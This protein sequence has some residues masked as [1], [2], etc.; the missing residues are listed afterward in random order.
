MRS[1]IS[2][3]GGQTIKGGKGKSDFV[4]LV[5]LS[6]DTGSVPPPW[7]SCESVS[8]KGKIESLTH[9]QVDAS[10][11]TALQ[12]KFQSLLTEMGTQLGGRY[13]VGAGKLQV[14][15]DVSND[16]LGSGCTGDVLLARS[17]SDSESLFAVKTYEFSKLA[18]E[19]DW[20]LLKIE[21]KLLLQSD[22]QNVLR[23]SDIYEEHNALHIVTPFMAGGDLR[24]A[25]LSELQIKM[26]AMQMLAG[27]QYLHGL[28]YIHRDIKPANFVFDSNDDVKIIDFGLCATWK[29]SG[30]RM[31]RQCG[32]HGF[33]SPEMCK[34][35][36]YTN[37][38]DLWS[39]GV[40]IFYLLETE[41]PFDRD[42]DTPP[43]QPEVDARIES[44]SF[45]M[46][47]KHFLRSLLKVD[48][49]ARPTAEQA[50]LHPWLA[51]NF[52]NDALEAPLALEQWEQY[53][54]TSHKTASSDRWAD[55][56]SDDED[57]ALGP[58]GTSQARFCDKPPWAD[59]LSDDQMS[60]DEDSAQ[61]AWGT[62]Q[63]RFCDKPRW[64]DF[65]SDEEN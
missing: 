34:H 12:S 65:L 62:S 50:L 35:Q 36:G 7:N 28:G 38:T 23:V 3:A 13:H 59:I 64:A 54:L 47:A 22:H 17:R 42:S 41:L 16:V 2:N 24:S 32:T 57:S 9:H 55:M 5:S 25:R 11:S 45:G 21:M 48:P 58:W 56:M 40:S 49:N 37:K 63:A 4:S 43:S 33:M 39:L 8:A 18:T 10:E 27:A 31:Q 46:L 60:D 20:T 15:Y 6:T 1:C 19:E 30:K 26:A 14:D 29:P 53:L 51:G 44:C 61:G 52:S